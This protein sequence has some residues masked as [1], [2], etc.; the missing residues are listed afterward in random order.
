MSILSNINYAAELAADGCSTPDF[1]VIVKTGFQAAV[2]A[3]LSLGVPGCTDI[4]KM[5]LGR[6]P[7]HRRGI[8]AL[9]KSARAPHSL[10][11]NRFLYKIG[12]DT[13]ERG[14]YYFMLADVATEFFVQW[15]SLAFVAEQCQ[16]PDAGVA[17][18]YMA[19][20][21]YTP[22]F[23][24]FMTPTPVH[25]VAGMAVGLGTINIFPGFK[26][27]VTFSCEWDS[28]PTRGEG[29]N[30]TTWMEEIDVPGQIS[31]STTNIPPSQPLNETVGH[32]GFDT[33]LDLTAKQFKFFVRNDG[34][35]AAQIVGG[36]YTVN[37]TGHPTG[38]LPFGCKFPKT[39]HSLLPF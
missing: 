20:F 27:S 38:I 22:N 3:L 37:M 26:G 24:G 36:T 31:V 13:A 11:G 33:L 2:P 1:F 32:T 12:Y 18:G 35:K 23:E 25:N 10:G 16:L 6:S 39:P 14:L 29:V 9:I 30:C 34:D 7:W 21:I 15:Q 8:R 17:Y 5:K 28:W 4:V 19:P